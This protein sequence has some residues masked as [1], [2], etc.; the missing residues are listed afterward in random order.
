MPYI[1]RDLLAYSYD[2]PDHAYRTGTNYPLPD[3][4]AA[5]IG[6]VIASTAKLEGYLHTVVRHLS[7]IDDETARIFTARLSTTPI[8]SL[9]EDLVP[10]RKPEMEK[11]LSELVKRL[12]YVFRIRNLVAHHEVTWNDY[13]LR[14]QSGSFAKKISDPRKTCFPI[15]L[16]EMKNIALLA[17]LLASSCYNLL[18][19]KASGLDLAIATIENFEKEYNLPEDPTKHSNRISRTPS[20]F[21]PSYIF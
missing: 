18:T 9:I 4:H 13:S 1:E 21:V 12:N 17:E 11:S 19:D 5:S 6:H 3:G 15:E 16:D 8:I 2:N 7:K 20:D 14:F 10:E